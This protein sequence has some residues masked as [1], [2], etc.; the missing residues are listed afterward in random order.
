MND[1]TPPRKPSALFVAAFVVLLAAAAWFYFRDPAPVP[2]TPQT[3]QEPAEPGIG[4]QPL[5][6]HPLPESPAESVED[7]EA[8]VSPLAEHLPAE[9]PDL[10]ASDT[11]IEGLANY[12]IANPELA[13]MLVTADAVRRLVATV[14]SLDGDSLPL[15]HLAAEPPA[16]RFLVLE[17]AGEVQLDERNFARYERHVALLAWLDPNEFAQ[18]YAHFYPLF[19]EAWDDL[20]KGGYFNDRL[21]EVIDLLLATPVASTPLQLE[22]PSVAYI[23]ADPELEAWSSG[24]KLLLRM[25]PE[26]AAAVKARLQAFRAALIS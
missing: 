19:Q 11:A 6:R 18:A 17:R 15:N 26:N 16:G 13:E 2:L 25:G 12:L 1:D 5:V 7:G 14:D 9:L 24:R 21:I 8:T 3:T 10:E 20:G 22:Q 4:S 23:H